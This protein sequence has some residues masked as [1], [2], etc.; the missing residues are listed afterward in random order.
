M[1][2]TLYVLLNI[3]SSQQLYAAHFIYGLQLNRPM[4]I[5]R[6]FF[7]LLLQD[8]RQNKKK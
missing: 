2:D 8:V 7:M 1:P 3:S 5:V 6:L 4:K